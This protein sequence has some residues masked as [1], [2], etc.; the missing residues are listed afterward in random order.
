MTKSV[1]RKRNKASMKRMI[2]FENG[3][4]IP[5][6]TDRYVIH[7][8]GHHLTVSLHDKVLRHIM[9]NRS[10]ANKLL[11]FAIL[12]CA[13]CSRHSKVTVLEIISAR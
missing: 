9:V 6:N 3:A 8:Y 5:D 13:K 7:D 10:N 1:N 4:S 12:Y 2:I 11:D